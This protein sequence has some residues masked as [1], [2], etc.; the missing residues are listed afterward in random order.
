[1]NKLKLGILALIL[2]GSAGFF[3]LT[4]QKETIPTPSP[5]PPSLSPTASAQLDLG[6]GGNSY[7]DPNNIF[8]FLY[9]NDYT[10]DTQDPL[11]IRIY[12]RGETQRPQSE[13]SN[14]ALLVFEPIKLPDTSL[15]T[16][17][18]TRIR[19]STADGT[20]EITEAKKSITQNGYPGFYY[21][22]RGLGI[23]QNLIL[24]KDKNS[25]YAV[26]ITY[27]VSDPK[28]R[29]YQKEVDAVLSSLTFIK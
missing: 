22:I 11:H 19:Q 23:S 18:D 3:I 10:L 25:D 2:I 29:G 14:G 28:E 24:Q 4:S 6:R 5:V 20:S 16:W 7:R 13:M 26:M 12:K 8:T 1:M 9:P 15:E 17:V 21:A 27:A